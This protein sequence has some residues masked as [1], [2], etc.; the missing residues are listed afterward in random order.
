MKKLI[1]LLLV[2]TSV[3][4]VLPLAVS[5][6][7]V[8]FP[9]VSEYAY[10]SF[11]AQKDISV[12]RN[13]TLSTRGTVSP[14]KTYNA[15][16]DQGDECKILKFTSDYLQVAYPTSSGERIGY[17]KRNAVIGVSAPTEKVRAS[18]DAKTYKYPRTNASYGYISSGDTVYKVGT[19]GSYT[20][21]I[22]DATSGNRS[23]KLGYVKTAEYNS[24]I[25]AKSSSVSKSRSEADITALLQ[26]MMDGTSYNGDYETETRYTGQY[27][28]EQC[29]GFAKSV[30]EKLFGYNIGSTQ[31]RDAGKNYK[32]NYT[33]SKTYYL[34]S[35]TDMEDDRSS[36]NAL[37]SLFSDARPGD[38]VQMRRDHGGS[39]SAIVVSVS[40]GGVTFVEVNVDGR[41]TIIEEYYSWSDL[42]DSNE[43]MSVCTAKSY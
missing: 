16:I 24:M 31:S 32:L 30:F 40:S 6:A 29:K 35:V 23:Y 39:H 5:A 34:G 33:S 26:D 42:C 13:P 11:I 28:T 38:F 25:A 8:A 7:S 12:F 17:I 14:S 21:V 1:A 10:C 37:K 20:A 41:N 18:Y 36:R 9:S 2:L 27:Y 3:L 43:A 19:S 22:Y 4:G 15:Y